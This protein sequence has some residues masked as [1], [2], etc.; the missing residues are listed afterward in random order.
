MVVAGGVSFCFGCGGTGLA[1]WRVMFFP[2]T[3]LFGS[4]D[5]AGIPCAVGVCEDFSGGCVIAGG[6][7]W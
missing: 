1:G 7:F 2:S 4:G 3:P 6:S 5:A